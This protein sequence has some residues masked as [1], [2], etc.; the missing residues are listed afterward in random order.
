MMIHKAEFMPSK[1]DQ[2]VVDGTGN[3]MGTSSLNYEG[4]VVHNGTEYLGTDA[5][6]KL[7][8][9]LGT[10]RLEIYRQGK[11]ALVVPD[12]DRR[13]SESLTEHK[14]RGFRRVPYRPFEIGS[15][16]GDER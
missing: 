10:G 2:S 5:V 12:I 11:L 16:R 8:R 14:E 6:G 4:Y 1:H 9:F 15:L 13:A 3:H 7:C